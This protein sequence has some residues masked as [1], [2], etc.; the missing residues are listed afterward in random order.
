MLPLFEK[1][2]G[3]TI[4]EKSPIWHIGPV[5]E[6]FPLFLYNLSHTTAP[7]LNCSVTSVTTKQ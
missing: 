5:K 7:K 1:K 4:V 2:T 6:G 3:G